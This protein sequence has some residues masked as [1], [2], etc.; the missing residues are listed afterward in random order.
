FSNTTLSSAL[1]ALPC[2]RTPPV[3]NPAAIAA[4]VANTFRRVVVVVVFMIFSLSRLHLAK[5]VGVAFAHG[6]QLGPLLELHMQIATNVARHT[7]DRA[8]ID[9]S[10]AVD[11]P[12][13]ARVELVGQFLDRL[14]YERLR[15]GRHYQRV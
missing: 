15:A 9:E 10:R 14:S 7:A 2:A 6:Q 11:L 8:D 13:Q 1:P 5:E 12:E 4:I 3:T